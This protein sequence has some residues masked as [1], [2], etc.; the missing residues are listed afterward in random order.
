MG[1]CS[2]LCRELKALILAEG[3]SLSCSARQY[4]STDSSGEH[5]NPAAN[6]CN[7]H[8]NHRFPAAT[9]GHWVG[10]DQGEEAIRRKSKYFFMSPCDKYHA[11]GRKP[12]KLIL[13]L[14]KIIMVTAQE[15][16]TMTWKHKTLMSPP[17]AICPCTHDKMS[18]NTSSAHSWMPPSPKE[19]HLRTVPHYFA[20]CS[21]TPSLGVNPGSG[22][23]ASPDTSQS[24]VGVAP[25]RRAHLEGSSCH[26]DASVPCSAPGDGSPGGRE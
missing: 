16:N 5:D 14:L 22:E 8:S 4:G 1:K 11:K 6:H 26:A 10:A 24:S 25:W 19:H 7:N 2:V 15:E 9:A 17:T 12:S 3:E 20:L 18:T 21:P 23:L 13:Q